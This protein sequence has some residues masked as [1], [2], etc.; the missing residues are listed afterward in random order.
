M[1][2][3]T[4]EDGAT[5]EPT[6]IRPGREFE[7]EYRL[8]AAAAGAFLVAVGERLRDGDSLTIEDP[9]GEWTLPFDFGEPVEL[10]LDY[11]GAGEPELELEVELPGRTGERAPDVS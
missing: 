3:D 4:H 11:E 10:E 6:T 1:A 5:A 7:R 8:D 9:D 2:G